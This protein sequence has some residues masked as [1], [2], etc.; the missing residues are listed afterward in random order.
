M[1]ILAFPA[2]IFVA[3]VFLV[4][5]IGCLVQI[6]KGF[7]EKFAN[8]NRNWNIVIPLIGLILVAVKPNGIFN[9]DQIEGDD[10]LL[11]HRE[12]A[13]NCMTTFKLKSN[14][15]FKEQTACFGT[16]EVS[17]Y[18]KIKND[19]ILFSEVR[20]SRG[21]EEYYEFGILKKDESGDNNVLVRYKNLKDTIGHE[22]WITKNELTD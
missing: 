8:R 22:L 20:I 15:K 4:L 19:T 2:L 12:G 17:G 5:A 1:G 16:Q 3:V 9:F 14:N 10:I 18:Y 21:S 7:K 11:A 13:A 6:F